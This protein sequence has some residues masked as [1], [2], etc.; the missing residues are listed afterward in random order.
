MLFHLLDVEFV[1]LLFALTDVPLRVHQLLVGAE[2]AEIE[3]QK[4]FLT[5]QQ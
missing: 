1:V 2:P 5:L 3:P 4:K